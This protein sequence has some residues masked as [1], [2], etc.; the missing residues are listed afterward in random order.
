MV[1]QRDVAAHLWGLAGPTGTVVVTVTDNGVV[2]DSQ[3]VTVRP[4]QPWSM[5]LAPHA[6]SPGA[7]SVITVV[8]AHKTLTLEDVAWGDV[9]VCGGQSNMVFGLGQDIDHATEC[10]ATSN[11]PDIRFMTYSTKASTPWARPSPATACT[12]TGFT[13]FSAVCW[14]FG[15]QVYE[16]QPADARVPIGLISSNVGGTA[17][18]RWSGPD[19]TAQCDQTGVVMQGDLYTP[20]IE[21]LTPMQ[22][23]GWIWYQGESNVANQHGQWHQG[24]YCGIGCKATDPQCKANQTACADFYA[25]QFPAMI[26]DWRAKWNGGTET[27]KGRTKGFF[28]VG[29]APYTEGVGAPGDQSVALLRMAQQKAL[30]LP[31]VAMGAAYDYG[32]AFSPLGD[33][34]PEFKGPVGF[35]LGLAAQAV[36]YGQDVSYANP[37][38]VSASETSPGVLTL[39]FTEPVEIREG[40]R[41]NWSATVPAPNQ[42]AWLNVNGVNAT[43]YV[44]Q[45]DGSVQVT[46]D[47]AASYQVDYLQGDWPVP[48]FYAKGS[49]NPGLPAAPFLTTVGVQA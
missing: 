20:L 5:D 49:G 41:G 33:I 12:G 24:S 48:I 47:A 8:D 42:N 22:V 46:V 45:A 29:L 31:S 27:I 7:Y 23:Q 19:A 26:T 35:R 30:K 14:Y 1:L 11:Y 10:P 6:A 2:V 43:K 15:K 4:G 17:I 16:S 44:A 25:C 40:H 36:I 3:N 9:F 34:H 28:F 13:P 21:P 32:D 39:K 38:F 18:E 37:M